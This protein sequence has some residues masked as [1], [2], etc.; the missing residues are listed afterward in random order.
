MI[1]LKTDQYY[2]FVNQIIAAV[3]LFGIVTVVL[4]PLIA[5]SGSQIFSKSV[6]ISDTME[7]SRTRT[8]QVMVTT[9][10]QQYDSTVTVFVSN[11]GIEDIRIHAVLI[12]GIESPHVLEDQNS[13][14]IDILESGNLGMIRINGVG[15][16][17]QIITDTGKLFEFFLG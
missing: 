9:G 6:S 11:I 12:D 8:G 15:D 13:Q 3:M 1:W 17:V 2:A 14:T 10:T 16:R 5:E 4:A 7:S